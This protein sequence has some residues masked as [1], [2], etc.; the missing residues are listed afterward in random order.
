MEDL[1]KFLFDIDESQLYV[2]LAVGEAFTN[3]YLI[4]KGVRN[5]AI[6]KLWGVKDIKVFKAI[7]L[8]CEGFSE[9]SASRPLSFKTMV[10]NDYSDLLIYANTSKVSA[11]RV[12]ELLESNDRGREYSAELG[13]ILGYNPELILKFVDDLEARTFSYA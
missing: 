9:D 5:V 11:N 2:G 4:A 1:E 13:T 8:Y 3:A 10:F 6:S 12:C 7:E